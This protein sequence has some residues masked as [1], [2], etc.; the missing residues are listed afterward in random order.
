MKRSR[1]PTLFIVLLFAALFVAATPQGIAATPEP[2][3]WTL[4][5]SV[6]NHLTLRKGSEVTAHIHAVIQP[7]WHVYALNQRPG[8][9]MAARIVVPQDQA[10]VLNGDIDETASTKRYDPNFNMETRLYEHEASFSIPLTATND[11]SPKLFIDVHYQA[12]NDTIC[13]EPTTAHL[14]TIIGQ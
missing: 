11:R 3:R 13:L 9:P 12:C 4:A 8:G 6:Q 1:T 10:F 14:S 7:G 2:I 5:A